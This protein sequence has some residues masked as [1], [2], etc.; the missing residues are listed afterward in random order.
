MIIL[1]IVAVGVGGGEGELAGADEQLAPAAGDT[2]EKV[3]EWE[4][5]LRTTNP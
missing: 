5:L 2:W 3:C 1:A 4:S